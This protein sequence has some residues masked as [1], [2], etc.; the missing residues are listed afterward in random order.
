MLIKIKQ[1]CNQQQK[2]QHFELGNDADSNLATMQYF[3]LGNDA[4]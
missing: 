2:N 1:Q 3:E 4:V